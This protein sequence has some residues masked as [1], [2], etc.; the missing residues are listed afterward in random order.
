MYKYGLNLRHT[1]ATAR[2]LAQAQELA[3]MGSWDLDLRSG[4][5]HWSPNMYRIFD[6]DPDNPDAHTVEYFAEHL[7]VAED[8]DRVLSALQEALGGGQA[9]EIQYQ[10]RTRNGSLRD[11]LARGDVIERSDSNEPLRML[12]T[13]QDITDRVNLER[14]LARL[15]ETLSESNAELRRINKELKLAYSR[16]HESESRYRQIVEAC[17]DGVAIVAENRVLYANHVL[18][19]IYGY[20]DPSMLLGRD[21]FELV[22]ESE[23]P[24]IQEFLSGQAAPGAA[25]QIIACQLL[26]SDGSLVDAEATYSAIELDGAPATLLFVR[27]VT[28]R[29]RL[30]LQ[31]RQMQKMDAIGTLAGGIAHDFNNILSGILGYSDLLRMELDEDSEARSYLEEVINAGQRARALVQRILTFS[32]QNSLQRSP[33]DI[34]ALTQEALKLLRASLPASIRISE[35]YEPGQTQVL[36]DPTELHQIVMNLCT[37]ASHAMAGGGELDVSLRR[38]KLDADFAAAHPPL[39]KGPHLLLTIRDNGCGMDQET[40]QRIFE[41]FF[42]TRSTGTGLGLSVVFGIIKSMG[43]ALTV[44]SEQGRGSVFNIYLPELG[45]GD[46]QLYP[47][48]ADS[49]LRGHGEHIAVVEDE[50]ALLQLTS[51]ILTRL[52]YRV[53]SFASSEEALL[54]FQAGTTIFDALL[55]DQT[56]P[57]MNGLELIHGVKA[58]LPG[59]P[60]ILASGFLHQQIESEASAAGVALLLAKPLV[61]DSLA[62]AVY[63]VLNAPAPEPPAQS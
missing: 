27:D 25:S 46:E 32:R 47:G 41:P 36:A 49:D 50:P 9:Y 28:E 13:V 2:L 14:R 37:N 63:K 22:P 4:Q 33:Q 42:T 54:A 16:Q 26:R 20:A 11:V 7:V 19:E 39:L 8:R 59:L 23:Y 62:Q 56:M 48:N 29:K 43:G 61:A 35:N 57:G 34:R 1:E 6:V 10:I 51:R 38:I 18:L 58:V 30:E 60:V 40:L 55:T 45:G 21:V 5:A 15:N 53:S 24:L 44:Y 52:G 31:V 12:G 3:A 17:P